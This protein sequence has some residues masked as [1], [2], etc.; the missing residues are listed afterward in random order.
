MVRVLKKLFFSDGGNTAGCH[1]KVL[2]F[3][4]VLFMVG[5]LMLFL[6]GGI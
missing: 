5:C 1:V 6:Q 2:V 3:I 4:D